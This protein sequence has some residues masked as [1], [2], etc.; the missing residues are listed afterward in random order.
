MDAAEFDPTGMGDMLTGAAVLNLS[1]ITGSTDDQ[2][3][4]NK[5]TPKDFMEGGVD[6]RPIN[7]R[8]IV[9]GLER[10]TVSN[11]EQEIKGLTLKLQEIKANLK[12]GVSFSRDEIWGFVFRVKYLNSEFEELKMSMYSNQMLEFHDR[13]ISSV[14]ELLEESEQLCSKRSQVGVWR[15]SID[16]DPG[17]SPVPDIVW[18]EPEEPLFCD[19]LED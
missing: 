19:Q 5:L 17:L 7:T 8:F 16:I 9:E 18:E 12:R 11:I 1:G 15:L 6:L 3:R 13:F 10:I 14:K 2:L 4:S